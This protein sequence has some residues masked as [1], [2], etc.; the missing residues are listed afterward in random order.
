MH[1][2]YAE[3]LL[4]TVHLASGTGG[5]NPGILEAEAPIPAH[6]LQR[7]APGASRRTQRGNLQLISEYE[8]N[9]TFLIPSDGL[10]GRFHAATASD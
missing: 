7:L 3:R 10:R 9:Y 8:A 1:G 2:T 4:L 6:Q 5:G